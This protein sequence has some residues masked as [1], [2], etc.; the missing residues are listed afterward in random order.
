[1]H[2]DRTAVAQLERE[3]SRADAPPQPEL[4]AALTRRALL[5]IYSPEQTDIWLG[6]H[7]SGDPVHVAVKALRLC[8]HRA[9]HVCPGA[10]V[11]QAPSRPSHG[12]RSARADLQ[13]QQVV[14]RAVRSLLRC[15]Q[16]TEVLTLLLDTVHQLGG[17]IVKARHADGRALPLDLSLG[18][19]EPL[20]AVPDPDAPEPLRQ[21]L[22]QLV[23]DARQ[24]IQ[25]LQRNERMAAAAELDPLTG[26]L[27]R[28]GYERLQGRLHAGDVLVLLDLDDFKM[29]NDTHGHV[30]GDQILRLFGA[31]LREEVRISEHAVRLG[32]DEFLVLLQ[33][34]TTDAG[35][36][37]LERLG[38]AWERRRPLP[39]GFSAGVAPV[40]SRVER[41]LE[42]ADR[43]LYDHKA[44]RTERPTVRA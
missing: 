6:A 34:A 23:E 4:V 25:R 16:R 24:T 2:S 19:G 3:I 5:G 12:K 13:T 8:S 14:T 40:I 38:I 20:L 44:A 1:M 33:N 30:A 37:F 11:D 7:A 41:A 28:R 36:R 32:G 43:S 29:V 9:S 10:T 21:Q 22:P 18:V 17:E 39:V 42:I 27:N 15:E 35:E 31:T 26:L